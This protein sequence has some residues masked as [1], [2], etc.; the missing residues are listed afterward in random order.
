[1]PRGFKVLRTCFHNH[2]FTFFSDIVW[3]TPIY[4]L[5]YCLCKIIELGTKKGQIFLYF[6]TKINY[7]NFRDLYLLY[8]NLCIGLLARYLF[9]LK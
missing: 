6:Y 7:P 5:K 1:M 3:L 2:A 9:K 8:I 4:P